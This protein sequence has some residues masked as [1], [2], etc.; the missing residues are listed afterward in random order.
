MKFKSF[1]AIAM[2]LMMAAACGSEDEPTSP[3]HRLMIPKKIPVVSLDLPDN[4]EAVDLGLSVKWASC[5]L[6]AD[7]PNDYGGYFGWGDP[8]GQLWSD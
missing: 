1:L 4:V 8:T 6:G 2:L 3:Q 5:N 7:A